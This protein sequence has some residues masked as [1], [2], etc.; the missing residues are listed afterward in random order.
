MLGFA[1]FSRTTHAA[2]IPIFQ[3][4]LIDDCDWAWK[5]GTGTLFGLLAGKNT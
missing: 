2:D 1:I 4:R 5:L 3:G